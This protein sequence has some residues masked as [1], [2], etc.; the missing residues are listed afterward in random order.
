MRT[1]NCDH[2]ILI[3][4]CRGC[5]SAYRD[6][7]YNGYYLPKGATVLAN[8]WYVCLVWLSAC[9]NLRSDH[10]RALLRDEEYYPDPDRFYPDRFLKDGK[11]N[12]K[13]CEAMP[14]FGY[15]RRYVKM[16]Y[17]PFLVMNDTMHSF[18]ICPGRHFAVDSLQM[19]IA[20]ILAVFNIDK[21]RDD[22]GQ[23]M[24]PEIEYISGFTRYVY[25][26]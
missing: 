16:S 9:F 7:T 11:I 24:E 26:L 20:S 3:V 6:D 10:L 18:R 19:S 14:N 2:T 21:A 25:V 17:Y 1:R 22:R 8:T 13:L 23:V 4:P 15:G 12:P 5:A